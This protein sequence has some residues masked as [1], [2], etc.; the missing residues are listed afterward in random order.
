MKTD[1]K[2][3]MC[4]ENARVTTGTYIYHKKKKKELHVK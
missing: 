3:D 1:L 4:G 2:V